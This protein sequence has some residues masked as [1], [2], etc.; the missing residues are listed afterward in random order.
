MR[1]SPLGRLGVD[2]GLALGEVTAF[3][4]GP[5]HEGALRHALAAGATRAV[6][7]DTGEPESLADWF[8]GEG[9]DLVIGDRRTALAGIRAGLAH[10]AGLFDLSLEG[11]VLAGK[12]SL[13]RGDCELVEADLPAVVRLRGDTPRYVTRHRLERAK[14]R[15]IE[16]I[17]LGGP[18]AEREEAPLAIARPRTRLGGA[19]PA[20]KAAGGMDRLKALMGGGGARKP[21]EAGGPSSPE[22]MAEE[23]VRYL[24]HHGLL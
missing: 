14:G 10:L 24:A 9:P 7:L 21:R 13:G 4:A 18:A 19:A 1:V 6:E 22:E 5:G 2:S 23:F 12:R 3:A 15:T 16:R 17:S 8:R 11:G 20:K